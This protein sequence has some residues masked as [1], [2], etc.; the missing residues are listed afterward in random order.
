MAARLENADKINIPDEFYADINS[1]PLLSESKQ[2][3]LKFRPETLGQASRI[4]GVT[5][6]D[7]QLISVAIEA[8]RRK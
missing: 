4:S 1:I 3:L 5:P 8:R 7:I 6:T 2:K